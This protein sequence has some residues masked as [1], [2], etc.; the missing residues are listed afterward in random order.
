[1]KFWKSD[2][3]KFKDEMA[4]AFEERNRGRFR[5][6][7]EHFS[8]AYEIAARSG[9]EG[10]KREGLLALAYAY[11]Y[12]AVITKSPADMRAAAEILKKLPGEPELD[13]ALARKVK[14][15][16]LAEELEALSKY[17]EVPQ[18]DLKNAK[19]FGEDAAKALEELAKYFLSRGENR[20]LLDEL[21]GIQE[22]YNSIGLKLLGRSRLIQA[23]RVE[24]ED[25]VRAVSLY[26]EAMGYFKA[27]ALAA[28]AIKVKIDK[29]GK[30]TRC[31]IC[32]RPIQGEEVNFVYLDTFLTKYMAKNFGSETPLQFDGNRVAVCSVCYGAIYNLSDKIS[33]YYYEKSLEAIRAVEERLMAQIAALRAEI[34]TLRAAT[35]AIKVSLRRGGFAID[36]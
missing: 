15:S 35:S 6:A 26:S 25:P 17:F 7:V 8:K 23:A 18:V 27:A 3:E 20:P 5:E 33:K 36:I 4:K 31:W 14:K 10:L 11:I 28:D 13:L 21:F 2:E 24:E 16:E 30:A 34:A 19:D 1:M 32:G 9:N 29:L 22:S 12:R